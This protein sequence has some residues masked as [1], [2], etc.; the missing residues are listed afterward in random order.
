MRKSIAA[1]LLASAGIAAPAWAA[2]PINSLQNVGQSDFKLLTEDLGGALSYKPLIPSTTLGITGFDIGIEATAT[3][4]NNPQVLTTASS[5]SSVSTVVVPKI[6]LHKG[7]PLGFDIG[8]FYSSV[9]T[10]NIKLVGGEVRY[11]LIDGGL[12][13]PTLSLRASYTKL[14]G[15][16]QL[17][18]NTKGVD[19][20]IAKGITFVTPYV[21]VGKVWAN[22]TPNGV[23]VLTAEKVSLNKVFGGVN[24]NFGLMN[25]AIEG[26]K[27]GQTTTYGAKLGF[28]W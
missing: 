5:G 10:T 22:A 28:R 21:G 7:L 24:F 23:P 1:V 2:G 25:F 20:S 12:I 27:T 15:V 11:A 18:F 14:T 8:A 13:K 6:A 3:K 17:D 26:D 4:L 16:D 9:P 19:I